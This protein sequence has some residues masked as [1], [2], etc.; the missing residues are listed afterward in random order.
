MLAVETLPCEKEAQKEEP[1]GDKEEG[2]EG[3]G[4]TTQAQEEYCR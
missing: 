3:G 2:R 4:G 1:E